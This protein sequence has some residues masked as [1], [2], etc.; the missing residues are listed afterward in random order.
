MKPLTGGVVT[1]PK[2]HK[3][4]DFTD[5]S[6]LCCSVMGTFFVIIP[7]FF[8]NKNNVLLIYITKIISIEIFYLYFLIISNT[9]E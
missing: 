9:E 2:L 4:V 1:F 5:L 7:I 6:H 3:T 8:L